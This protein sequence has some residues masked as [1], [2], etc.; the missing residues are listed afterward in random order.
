MEPHCFC[1][2]IV[3]IDPLR[4]SLTPGILNTFFD[5]SGRDIG[6]VALSFSGIGEATLPR[7]LMFVPSATDSNIGR[8]LASSSIRTDARRIGNRSFS[9]II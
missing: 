9:A 2:V 4:P 7:R 1:R 5:S 8:L 6:D 3:S